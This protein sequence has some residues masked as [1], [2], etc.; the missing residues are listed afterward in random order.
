[1]LTVVLSSKLFSK[2]IITEHNNTDK[3]ATSLHL[4]FPRIQR[5]RGLVLLT[6]S[7]RKDL[8]LMY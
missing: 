5:F 4:I 2:N 1:M 7:L 6:I 3:I 8:L